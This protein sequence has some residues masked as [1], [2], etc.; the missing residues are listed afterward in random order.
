MIQHTLIRKL[1]ALTLISFSVWGSLAAQSNPPVRCGAPDGSRTGLTGAACA[2]TTAVPFLTIA[3]DSR[4]GALGEA[5]VAINN[6]PS[7][8]HWNPS[9][10]A[11]SEKQFAFSLNYS[12]WLRALGI[13]DINL[14]YLPAYYNFG[15]KG[16]VIGGAIT[17]FSL[18]N[19]NLTNEV[20]EPIGVINPSEFAISTAYARQ[21]TDKLSAG[22]SLR[23]VH[24]NLTG[25][26]T[27]GGVPTKPGQSFAGDLHMFYST[28]F[29]Y[30]RRTDMNFSWGVNISNLGAK[31]NYT[32][33]AERDFMPANLRLGYALRVDLDEYNS[34]AFTNDFNKLLVPFGESAT[35]DA[36]KSVV[37]GALSSFNDAPG[38]ISEELTEITTSIGVE[39]WYNNLFALRTGYFYEDPLK[40]NRKF[41]TLGAAIRFN[42]FTLDMAYLISIRRNH[43]L[44][45]TLRFSLSFEFGEAKK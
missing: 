30:R 23:Y 2:I 18:G 1:L 6:S 43:P 39:Y 8:L 40:G 44:A 15:P 33:T 42:V 20:G 13:P 14:A 17:F 16:G 11:F 12:P 29:V 35:D 37:E 5:G 3:P 34:F 24:S 45:N 31:M 36:Q 21:V 38:G 41:A 28:D 26:T 7:A 32:N 25:T 27:V 10:L 22:V 19:I 4:S 9:I